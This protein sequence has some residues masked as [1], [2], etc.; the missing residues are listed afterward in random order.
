MLGLHLVEGIS[1]HGTSKKSKDD[2]RCLDYW[3]AKVLHCRPVS[4]PG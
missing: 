1:D 3:E 2:S 4:K